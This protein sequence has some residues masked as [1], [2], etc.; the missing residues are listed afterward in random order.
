MRGSKA[1]FIC[2]IILLCRR[3]LIWALAS[4]RNLIAALT[5]AII[6]FEVPS[7]VS[8]M[9]IVVSRSKAFS[10]CVCRAASSLSVALAAADTYLWF[11]IIIQLGCSAGRYQK[12]SISIYCLKHIRDLNKYCLCINNA[13]F[14]FHHNY[15]VGRILCVNASHTIKLL[16]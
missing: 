2:V 7:G 14:S 13:K 10:T 3:W 15:N 8:I 12:L 6:C 9:H 1:L 11:Q 5:V 16:G 4:P